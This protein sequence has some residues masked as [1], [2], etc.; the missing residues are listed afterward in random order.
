MDTKSSKGKEIRIPAPDD[1]ITISR[2][3]TQ[4][5]NHPNTTQGA[6]HVEDNTRTEQGDRS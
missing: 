2:A 3:I 1:P 4:P 6:E 5:M